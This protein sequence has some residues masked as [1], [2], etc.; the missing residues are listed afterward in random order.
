LKTFQKFYSDAAAAR[1]AADLEASGAADKQKQKVDGL[2]SSLQ[3][4]Q[5][6]LRSYVAGIRDS[7]T[8][9]VSLSSAFSD[10]SDQEKTR[11]EGVADALKERRDAY[12]A[13]QQAQVTN[14]ANAYREALDRITEAER[15]VKTAQDVKAKSYT[16][17]FKE[18][19]AA[20]KEFGGNL[21]S[22][23]KAGLGKAGLAQLLNLGPVAGN[24]V[25]KDILSGTG[26]L[27]VGGLNA[28]LAS[29]AAAGTAVGMSIPGVRP[30]LA[31]KVGNTYQITV[32]AGIGDKAEIGRE[33]VAVLQ[34]Y[35][36]RI[37]KIPIKVS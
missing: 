5:S 1:A 13:L 10:A 36:K 11:S 37:G 26:G 7:V 32:N 27:T 16:D 20:A 28:D 6:S 15:N 2:R 30:A 4:A 23:I 29:V 35:E 12:T 14:D 24:T 19:I 34:A 8:A 25:A 17:I 33:V 22:L 9:S 21:Q 3:N 18:Q 31:A